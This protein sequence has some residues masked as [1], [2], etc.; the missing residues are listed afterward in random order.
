MSLLALA[1]LAQFA[2]PIGWPKLPSLLIPGIALA[3]SGVGFRFLALIRFSIQAV[4]RKA[5]FV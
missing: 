2:V 3:E 1:A 5:H 4:V